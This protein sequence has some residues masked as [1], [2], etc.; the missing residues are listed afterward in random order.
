M[1]IAENNGC[2]P[3]D[4]SLLTLVRSLES[5]VQL[6]V[7]LSELLHGLV[8][9]ELLKNLLE[10][11]LESLVLSGVHT[12]LDEFVVHLAASGVSHFKF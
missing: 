5:S 3:P 12:H 7:F 6:L 9:Y 2:L 4:E 8:P 1:E 10:V 11:L